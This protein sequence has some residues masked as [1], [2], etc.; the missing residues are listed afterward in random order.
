VRRSFRGALGYPTNRTSAA[1]AADVLTRVSL[2][3]LMISNLIFSFPALSTLF[4]VLI[5]FSYKYIDISPLHF[6]FF[7]RQKDG[8]VSKQM[9]SFKRALTIFTSNRCTSNLIYLNTF[10]LDLE[11][12]KITNFFLLFYFFPLLPSGWYILAI[13]SVGLHFRSFTSASHSTPESSQVWQTF[14]SIIQV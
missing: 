7:C 13:G 6:N 8:N 3:A 11:G 1:L 14:P 4:L 9:M 12:I 10:S 5:S 2:A